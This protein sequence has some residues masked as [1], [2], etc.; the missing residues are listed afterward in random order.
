[1]NYPE[2][3]RP[4]GPHS[5]VIICPDETCGRRFEQTGEG[6]LYKRRMERLYVLHRAW[7]HS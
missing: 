5:K 1:M 7:D 3:I 6:K 4:D 2:P